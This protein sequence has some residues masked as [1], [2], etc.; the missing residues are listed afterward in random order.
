MKGG[1]IHTTNG[2]VAF[3]IV[4]HCALHFVT[5]CCNPPLFFKMSKKAFV[6]GGSGF[7]GLNLIEK[8][9]E[10]GW[11]VTALHRANSDLTY[12]K[13]F[14][15]DLVEGEVQD[16]YSLE[17][18]M[19]DNLDAVFHIAGDTNYWKRNNA[20]QTEINVGGTKNMVEV[21]AL[22]H[23]KCFIHTSSVSAWGDVTGLIDEQTPQQGNNS[24][25]NYERTKW[26]GEQEALKGV[27]MGMKVVVLNPG[28]VVGPY[29]KNTWG[30][31]FF[32]I[33]KGELPLIPPGN[34]CITHVHEVVKAH[35]AAVDKGR[36]GQHYILGGINTS[37]ALFIGEVAKCLDRKPP[38]V[39]NP[40]MT[41]ILGWVL[42]KV[43]DITNKPPLLTSELAAMTT[44]MDY[45]FSSDLAK[46][47]LGFR[48]IPVETC[49]R[50]C[51]EWL[52]KE[53]L[54]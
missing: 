46:K 9:I 37:F 31:T 21:A 16:K 30:K 1:F 29:D 48:D 2:L 51:Y 27:K 43:G 34:T 4:Y 26:A 47:E 14:N 22:K 53:G 23:A 45:R 33:Q 40:I 54:V 12:L 8:L 3:P 38:A 25:I 11:S 36:N 49:V 15:I 28:S 5:L 13:K 20:L 42:G 44:R 17:N 6:T 41:K 24:F 10:A 39:G 35:I 7:L 32:A 19:P 52:K 18:I 50:D